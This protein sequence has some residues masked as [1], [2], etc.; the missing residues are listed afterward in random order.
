MD[1]LTLTEW[2]Q[3]VVITIV[4]IT[5]VLGLYSMAEAKELWAKCLTQ[6]HIVPCKVVEDKGIYINGVMYPANVVKDV[7]ELQ[8]E[9]YAIVVLEEK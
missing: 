8:E 5:M 9:V 1:N 7:I 4:F 2:L 3:R 6:K